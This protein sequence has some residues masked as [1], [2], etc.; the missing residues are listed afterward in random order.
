MRKIKIFDTIFFDCKYSEIR[1]FIFNKGYLVIPSGP[2]LSEIFK[3]PLYKKALNESTIA[4]FD[5][6]LLCLLLRLIKIKVSKF[7]GYKLLRN[8]FDDFKKTNCKV[9]LVDPTKED[10]K[11]NQL[12]INQ[13][14]KNI[15]T[16]TYIAPY[17]KDSF[18]D[19]KLV[20]L[21]NKETPNY[22]IINLGGFTQEPLA[23]YLY[24][25]IKTNSFIICSGAAIAFFTGRQAKVNSFI[26]NAY[27]GWLVRCLE[28]PKLFIPRYL[29]A[30]KLIYVFLKNKNRVIELK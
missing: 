23:N 10:S 27:L 16:I 15:S 1:N 12:Y 3:N 26:D 14:N 18:E 8:L 2:G 19:K 30:F 13:L 5:S 20:K 7:S 21:I 22:I 11:I 25:N 4:I 6:S 28:N 17:Y 24:K 29:K 9:L